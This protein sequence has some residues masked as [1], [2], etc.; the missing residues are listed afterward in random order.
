M[1]KDGQTYLDRVEF[2]R[3]YDSGKNATFRYGEGESL[4]TVWNGIINNDWLK[5]LDGCYCGIG[6]YHAPGDI[7]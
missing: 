2:G 3:G 7:R 6:A 4:M 1:T 5:W